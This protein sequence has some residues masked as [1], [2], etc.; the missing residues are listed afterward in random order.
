VA[1]DAATL[2]A[3]LDVEPLEHDLFRGLSP[4]GDEQQRVFGGQVV[5]QAL[6]SAA[7]TVAAEDHAPHSLHAYSRTHPTT[8]RPA[9]RGRRWPGPTGGSRS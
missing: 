8:A 9:R 2:L 4:E 5:A 3:L 1:G 6:M 7:R